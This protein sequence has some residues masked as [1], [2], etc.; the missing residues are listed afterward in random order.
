MVRVDE[1]FHRLQEWTSGQT[2]SERLAAQVLAYSGYERIDPSHPMGGRDGGRDGICTKDGKTWS[3]AVY[4]PRGQQ[5]L[6]TI[7]G[8][9]DS[10]LTKAAAHAPHGLAFVTNQELRMAERAQL[11]ESATTR[12][13]AVD[14]FHVERV[15]AVLD[16]PRM[17]L[18]RKQYLDIEPGP[19]PIDVE[20]H[21]DGAARYFVRS[22]EARDGYVEFLADQE[23]EKYAARAA[24]EA[25]EA[26]SAPP[27]KPFVPEIYNPM[28]GK[29]APLPTQEEFDQRLRV[30]VARTRAGWAKSE[31]YLA[32]HRWPGL[33]FRLKNVG[34][35]F[36]NDVQVIITIQGAQGAEWEDSSRFEQDDFV[37][38]LRP[39][40]PDM[41]SRLVGA[42]VAHGE[43]PPVS[44]RNVTADA[45]EITLN[46]RHLRPQPEWVSDDDDMVLRATRV[47]DS[48]VT[49]TWMVT[50]QD[51]GKAHEGASL[52]LPVTGVSHDERLR[53]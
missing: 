39:R 7:E 36:L 27:W 10:D 1:T 47:E 29:P 8:K 25:E 16:D 41:F 51:Y 48:T 37:K 5:T 21:I 50:A 52:E 15:M 22:D 9:F 13:L 6:K 46:L 26:K 4:F 42:A 44:W 23:R 53:N 31:E 43:E 32:A 40:Q 38:P 11:V 12:G 45:V 20:L 35:V 18:V 49:A 24:R 30:W 19:I 14:L 2:P 17:S 28:L 3:Y 33:R 34:E